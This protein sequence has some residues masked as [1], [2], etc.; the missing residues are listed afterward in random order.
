VCPRQGGPPSTAAA[1]AASLRGVRRMEKK[2]VVLAT[3]Q[4]NLHFVA[5]DWRGRWPRRTCE[6]CPSSP[7]W[8]LA[9]WGT[10]QHA[11]RCRFDCGATSVPSFSS[12]GTVNFQ[13]SFF[14]LFSLVVLL[15]LPG[16]WI[17]RGSHQ[18]GP[19][20]QSHRFRSPAV[21][22]SLSL[23][24]SRSSSSSFFLSFFFSL[25]FS[26]SSFFLSFFLSFSLL[27]VRLWRFRRPTAERGRPD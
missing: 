25:F 19:V 2:P 20:Q 4:H 15:R 22:F 10:A 17:R 1:A 16:T 8:W 18:L 7:T 23:N 14:L 11:S 5:A 27:L 21:F 24:T 12:F 6:S 9:T 13:S 26:S 3:N